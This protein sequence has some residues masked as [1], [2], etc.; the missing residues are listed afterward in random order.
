[1]QG[2]EKFTVDEHFVN[3]EYFKEFSNDSKRFYA[4]DLKNHKQINNPV[5]IE[6]QCRKKNLYELTEEQNEFLIRNGIEDTLKV[7]EGRFSHE[8]KNIKQRSTLRCI[9]Y[10]SFFSNEEIDFWKFFITLQIMRTPTV[11]ERTKELFQIYSDEEIDDR[12]AKN[13]ALLTCFPFWDKI[14]D[15]PDKFNLFHNLL[16]LTVS[17][18]IGLFIDKNESLFTSDNPVFIDSRGIRNGSISL[19]VYPLT[20]RL[21]IMLSG[22][23]FPDYKTLKGNGL[24]NYDDL[25]VSVAKREI[26]RAAKRWIYSKE[27][28]TID[29]I[30]QIEEDRRNPNNLKKKFKEG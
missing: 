12:M 13:Y 16:S 6:S 27:K 2:K 21:V 1:M 8:R 4:Y 23:S 11:I 7:Y 24:C 26:A 9:K 17:M 10:D 15:E 22:Y 5:T 28:L 30:N 29:E 25:I 14:E 3:Q 18:K 20:P 19:I